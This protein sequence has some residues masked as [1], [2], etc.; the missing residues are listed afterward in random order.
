MTCTA[1]NAF[2]G[3]LRTS[4]PPFRGYCSCCRVVAL[5]RDDALR[6]QGPPISL[7]RV[8]TLQG[9]ERMKHALLISF[10]LRLARVTMHILLQ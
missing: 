1:L 3:L 10:S 9:S 4:C 2:Y 5:V 8:I 7:I 6:P